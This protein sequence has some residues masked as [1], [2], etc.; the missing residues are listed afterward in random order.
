MLQPVRNP[1][2]VVSLARSRLQLLE[3]WL[4]ERLEL[5]QLRRL[6]DRELR[7]RRREALMLGGKEAIGPHVIQENIWSSYEAI[8]I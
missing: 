4:V 6:R 3:L 8:S 7:A 2:G 1:T 5:E